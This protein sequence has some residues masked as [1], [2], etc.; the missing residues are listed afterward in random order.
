MSADRLQSAKRVVIKIG[1]ALLVDEAHGTVHR[2]WLEALA[3]DVAEMKA[4]GQDV[5]L[6]SSG[7]IAVGRRYLGLAD[8][9]L[10]LD[11]KQAAAATGQIR[12][13]HAYQEVLGHHD[14]TVAQVLL[15]LDDTESR[16]RYLNAR[17]TLGAI[18]RLGAV[19][20]IN[21]NDTVATDE[22]RF[23]DNDRLGARVAAM[24]S[25]D[26]LVLLSDVD[27]LYTANPNVDDTARHIAEVDAITPEIEAMAGG[28][29]SSVGSG[30]MVTKLAAAKICL[31]NGCAMAITLGADERPL[32]RL[33]DGAQATWFRPS[34]TPASARKRWIAGSLQPS[35]RVILDDGALS[36][37]KAGKSLL[38]I[39]VTAVHGTFDKGD[40]VVIEDKNGVELARGLSAYSSDDA[41]KIIGRKS[42]EFEQVLGYRGRDELV[43]RDDMALS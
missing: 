23:G 34:M 10:K 38:P 5:I 36:A 6:V 29:A 14:I 7:A 9:P 17:N 12:L 8:G 24:A 4:R 43:H 18:L 25:A 3:E 32:K 37:L 19:P 11:E 21:E 41:Q 27:G 26:V 39:G 42:S 22:I 1:S 2:K 33:S 40:A 15:T 28:V 35:G 30:G 20:L 31:Q 13:A 16:R